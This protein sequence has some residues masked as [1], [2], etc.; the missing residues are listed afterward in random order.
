[1]RSQTSVES[2]QIMRFNQNKSI[3]LIRINQLIMYLKKVGPCM[4]VN[5]TE[6]I[7]EQI[8]ISILIQSAGYLNPLLLSATKVDAS[9]AND[10]LVTKWQDLQVFVQGA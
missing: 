7:I 2:V 3:G 9:L 4:R 8:D 10:R 5:C 6:W 1:M